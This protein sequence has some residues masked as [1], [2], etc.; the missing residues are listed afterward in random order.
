M[1]IRSGKHDDFGKSRGYVEV[2]LADSKHKN[3]V[4]TFL[5]RKNPL[6]GKMQYEIH[7]KWTKQLHPS[8]NLT[9]TELRELA[10]ALN[11][12]ANTCLDSISKKR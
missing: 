5:K 2:D 10:A 8:M 7:A 12:L 3:R 6:T 4:I 1:P 9:K 11:E